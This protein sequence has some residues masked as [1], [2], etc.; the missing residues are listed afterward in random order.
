[1]LSAASSLSTR[2]IPPNNPNITITTAHPPT[3]P[4]PTPKHQP[5]ERFTLPADLEASTCKYGPLSGRCF[6]ERAVAAYRQG[7]LAV[8]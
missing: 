4:P 1:M 5:Q 6:E 3:H 7:L 2:Y 8:K